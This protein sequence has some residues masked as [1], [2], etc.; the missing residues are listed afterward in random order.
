MTNPLWHSIQTQGLSTVAVMGM[1][2]NTG[3]TVALNHLLAQAHAAS[4]RVGVTSIGRD[5]EERDQVYQFPKPPVRVWPR[6]LVA[7]ARD[8]LAR[9]KSRT[10]FLASTGIQSPMGE[11]VLVQVLEQGEMEIAGASRSSDQRRVIARLQ[12][13]GAAL[14]LLDG[15]LGRSQHASPSIADGVLLATG[16]A[17]GG[18]I[19]DVLRKTRDR[20]AILS[21]EQADPDTRQ[22]CAALFSR[23]GVALWDRKGSLVFSAPIATLNA[24]ETLLH[25]ADFPLATVALTGAVGRSLWAVLKTLASR[26]PGLNIVVA[27]GTKLFVDTSKLAALQRL[28]ARVQVFSAIRLLGITLNPFAPFGGSFDATDFLHAARAAFAGTTVCDVVL[29]EQETG[30]ST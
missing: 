6:T 3:K 14:V 29:E 23:G 30:V 5:G 10:Q 24:G 21:I 20:L 25:Y 12:Q 15:A 22:R 28:G 4:M 2:K 7:T 1:S 18:G 11:I 19:Q 8:T 17:I 16:A 26:H 13:C 27:D 9:A